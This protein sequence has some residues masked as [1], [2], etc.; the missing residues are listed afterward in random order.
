MTDRARVSR[1]LAGCEAA[2]RAPGTGGLAEVFTDDAV[3][4]HSPYEE[5]VG[6]LG[7]IRRMWDEDREGPQE[8]FTLAASVLAVGGATVVVRAGVGYGIRFAR[9]TATYGSYGCVTTAGAAGWRSGPAG[10]DGLVRPRR[11]VGFRLHISGRL[12]WRPGG[13]GRSVLLRRMTSVR[14]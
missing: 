9:S 7:A 4:L 6:G 2:W 1:W 11:L 10:P 13:A 12:Q 3:Y 5:S 14:Y 8:V